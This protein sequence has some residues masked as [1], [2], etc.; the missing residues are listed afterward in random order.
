MRIIFR[1]VR[2]AV[3]LVKID[4]H[5]FMEPLQRNMKIDGEISEQNISER[6]RFR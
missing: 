6:A 1:E 3:F 2:R 4:A 5:Y